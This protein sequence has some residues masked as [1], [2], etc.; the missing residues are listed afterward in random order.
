MAR[1]PAAILDALLALPAGGE[2]LP[3]VPGTRFAGL[4]A[5]VAGELSRIEASGESLLVESD[6]RAADALL[7]E[8]EAM[9]GLPDPCA[10]A[11]ALDGTPLLTVPQRR[12]LVVQRVTAR[13]AARPADF[14]ALAASV[15]VP[16]TI[17]E[18]RETTCEMSCETPACGED[19]RFAF[20]VQ[21]PAVTVADATC[22]EG[23][24]TPLR[25]WGNAALECVIRRAAP[26]HL[27]PIFAYGA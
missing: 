19:W 9:A 13:F 1:A 14:V 23:C 12:A 6:P 11:F 3:M 15:G 7:P 27:T 17:A 22:E 16:V 5:G 25:V 21:A 26:A 20:T 10:P 8:W 2:A 4:L 18:G 24:E